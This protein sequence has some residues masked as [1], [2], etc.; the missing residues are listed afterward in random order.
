MIQF[1]PAKIN[2]GLKVIR[3]RSDGYHDIETLMYPIGLTDVLEIVP[4]AD[5]VFDF[6]STG[7][8]IDGNPEDNL[9][10]RACRLISQ[11]YLL[12][13]V[14]I[15]LHKIIP[16]GAGLGGGSSDA[17]C[18]LKLIRR[19][20]SIKMCNNE[21]EEMAATLGSDCSFFI[22]GK[23]ALSSGRGEKL[24]SVPIKLAGYHLLLVKPPLNISTAWAYQ[25]IIPLGESLP[26][27]KHLSNNLESYAFRLTNDFEG[28]A[29]D[30]FPEIR[31]IKEKIVEMGAVY[32][33]MSGSGA[34]VYGLF[35]TAL[36]LKPEDFPGAF[37]WQEILK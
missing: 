32:A 8:N 19:I 29:M 17:A 13:E 7:L 14:K 21:L 22:N 26:D 9:C 10:V 1:P 6:V 25:N 28:I 11:K 20:F 3:K 2:I 30:A 24:T 37:I 36:K 34:A 12:P 27:I 18:V 23:P 31:R 5:G 35:S 33:A 15:H 4:S 16:Y